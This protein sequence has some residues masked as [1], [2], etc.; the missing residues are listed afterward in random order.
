[1]TVDRK[2]GPIDGGAEAYIEPAKKQITIGAD[3][4]T[5]AYVHELA[6]WTAGHGQKTGAT[7]TRA[8]MEMEAEAIA[9]VVCQ[10]LGLDA[11]GAP[12]YIA[13]WTGDKDK[14]KARM[15]TISGCA[16]KIIDAVEP[17]QKQTTEGE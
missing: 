4:G 3:S 13:L 16:R 17:K 1:L 11:T 10:A 14:L 7:T 2:T 12:N 9:W 5:C 15:N 6:H 8:E